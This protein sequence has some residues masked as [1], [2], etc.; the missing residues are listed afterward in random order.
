MMDAYIASW[1]TPTCGFFLAVV[2]LALYWWYRR[3]HNFPPGPRGIPFLGCIPLLEDPAARTYYKWSKSYGPVMS[4]RIGSED[5]VT[6]N[7]YDAIYE[8]NSFTFH[9]K[10]IRHAYAAAS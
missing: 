4:V 5:W 6:L 1:C 8:V 3:P 7:D 9:N 2:A 10:N